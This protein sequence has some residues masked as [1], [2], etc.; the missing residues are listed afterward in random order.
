MVYF[1]WHELGHTHIWLPLNH[2]A[3]MD[4]TRSRWTFCFDLESDGFIDGYNLEQMICIISL[5]LCARVF[6]KIKLQLILVFSCQS[7]L[8][9]EK[10]V[11]AY[12]CVCVCVC[13][14]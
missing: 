3:R 2:R 1:I 10:Y 8:D 13:V 5:W 9:P 6:Q 11:K 14:C 12:L 7:A 4:S